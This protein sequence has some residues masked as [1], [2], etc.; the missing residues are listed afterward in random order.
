MQPDNDIIYN[1][2]GIDLFGLISFF[3]DR[4]LNLGISGSEV[5]NFLTTLWDIFSMLAFL[6]SLLFIVG[7][8]YSYLKISEYIAE[9]NRRLALAESTWR[10]LHQEKGG[11]QRWL[12]VERHVAGDRPNDWKLAIIDSDIMLGE[13][14]TEK[15]YVGA[16][17]GDQLKGLNSLQLSSLQDAWDAHRIRNRIAHEGGDFV[18][19]QSAAREAIV[20][21]QRVLAE[22]GVI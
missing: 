17:I 22:L 14:L 7:I 3:F 9:N 1:E 21:Y 10:E 11:S 6:V 19:T 5:W 13:A 4:V 12:D 18:L 16:S 2:Y 20:K 8:V 15:G